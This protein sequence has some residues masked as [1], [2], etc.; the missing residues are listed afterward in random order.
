MNANKKEK[1]HAGDL[2]NSIIDIATKLL[3]S[4]G[5]ETISMR[6]IAA[7]LGVSRAA[8][9]R[10]FVDKHDLL[11]VIAQHSFERLTTAMLDLDEKEMEPKAELFLLADKYIDF[12]LSYPALYHLMFS[13][14]ELSNQ[15]TSELS[16]SA[17]KLF[18]QL[19]TLLFKFQQTS[20]I[21]T[22]DVNLQA[23]YVWSS[24]HGYC[25]LLL[26]Q[27]AT[28]VEKLITHQLFFLDKIWQAL[29]LNK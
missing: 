6:T 3:L 16:I 17:S 25:C 8:P 29:S 10:H 24:L 1:Y 20:V 21:K 19:E 4:G 14:P 15:Q 27:E 28:K 2:K 11:C 23:N 13:E 18:D 7:E 9:Y 5:I 12:C 22:E 26:S